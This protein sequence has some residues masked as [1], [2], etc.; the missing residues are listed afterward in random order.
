M[1]FLWQT[2]STGSFNIGSLFSGLNENGYNPP[3]GFCFDWVCEGDQPIMDDKRLHD[4]NVDDVIKRFKIE[5]EKQRAHFKGNNIMMTMG[6]DFQYRNAFM[7]YKNLDKLIKYVNAADVGLNLIYSTPSCYMKAKN[8][9]LNDLEEVVDDFFPYADGPHMFWTGY[10]TS[11]AALKR[12]VR[13]TNVFLA[14]CKLADIHLQGKMKDKVEILERAFAVAQHHDACNPSKACTEVIQSALGDEFTRCDFL[15]ISVCDV[16]SQNDDFEFVVINP[17]SFP[18]AKLLPIP[19][20]YD[21]GREYIITSNGANQPFQI[22]SNMENFVKVQTGHSGATGFQLNVFTGQLDPFSIN[23]FKVSSKKQES[24]PEMRRRRSIVPAAQMSPVELRSRGRVRLTVGSNKLEIDRAGIRSINGI[25]M[26][27]QCHLWSYAS[28]TASDQASGA[29][30]FRPTSNK[31]A[32]VGK[33]RVAVT[34]GRLFTDVRLKYNSWAEQRFRFF[35]HHP[36]I[37]HEFIIGELPHPGMELIFRLDTKLNTG[38]SFVTDTNGRGELVRTRD[39]R[40]TWKLNQ[41][42]K[43]AGNYYPVTS[44]IRINEESTRRSVSIF[45]DRA[46]GGSSVKS[47]SVE[48]MLLRETTKDDGR[49]VDEPL[50][51]PGQFGKGLIV[52]GKHLILFTGKNQ[53]RSSNPL[54]GIE[55]Q[56]IEKFVFNEP[57]VAFKK[58]NE[59]EIKLTRFGDISMPKENTLVAVS[60]LELLGNNSHMIRLEH[61]CAP[62][63]SCDKFNRAENF[64]FSALYGEYRIIKRITETNIIGN[65]VKGSRNR[66]IWPKNSSAEE[67]DSLPVTGKTV[68]IA[69]MELRTF[70][71]DFE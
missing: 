34:K 50:N 20:N 71:I 66:L 47:G 15:N 19:I 48:L 21:S 69:P 49:G 35:E 28:S 61:L 25:I 59:N 13:E 68:V 11:R 22:S 64:D 38:K 51:D 52:Q 37:E 23:T 65:V 30:I 39:A 63:Q 42:E 36:I 10:F 7:W 58:S 29:Y 31:A 53:K 70:I 14:T 5:A 54:K 43:I 46:Q 9:E 8:E 17:G 62:G 4:Y 40:K 3:P 6:S 33:P 32:C 1:E 55:D 45:P 12:Y 18:T 16:S 57:W 26:R 2:R 41:T 60:S 27:S 44:K 56:M 24:R 67:D